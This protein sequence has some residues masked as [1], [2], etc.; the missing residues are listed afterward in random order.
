MQ[1]FQYS[2]VP[3]VDEPKVEKKSS[4]IRVAPGKRTRAFIAH[5]L[6]KELTSRN[7][8]SEVKEKKS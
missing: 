5:V 3:K 2:S 6:G 8:R 4:G 1:D 7:F